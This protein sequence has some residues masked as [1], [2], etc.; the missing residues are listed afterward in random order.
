MTQNRTSKCTRKGKYAAIEGI[1]KKEDKHT[2]TT[3]L[4]PVFK[5]TISHRSA[6]HSGCYS[7]RAVHGI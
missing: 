6:P 2:E 7:R 4:I 3:I 5:S 1:N